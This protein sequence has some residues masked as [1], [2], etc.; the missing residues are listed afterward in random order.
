MELER[1]PQTKG[2]PTTAS[3]ERKHKEKVDAD[4]RPQSHKKKN[5]NWTDQASG[6][7]GPLKTKPLRPLHVIKPL[8]DKPCV[9]RNTPSLKKKRAD[10]T[11][12]EIQRTLHV[13]E[14]ALQA[15]GTWMEGAWRTATHMARNDAFT[16]RAHKPRS[17]I[18]PHPKMANMERHLANECQSSCPR[19]L[20]PSNQTSPNHA[21]QTSP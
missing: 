12:R 21:E 5:K 2:I 6:P 10:Q 13:S 20:I 9:P 14:T 4:Q 15:S 18:R 8:G 11:S 1:P 19:R 7:K 16:G 17:K 3:E